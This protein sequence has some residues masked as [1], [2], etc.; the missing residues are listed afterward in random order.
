MLINPVG[1]TAV[2]WHYHKQKGKKSVP[3]IIIVDADEALLSVRFVI[4]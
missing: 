3:I 1:K 4:R 2:E